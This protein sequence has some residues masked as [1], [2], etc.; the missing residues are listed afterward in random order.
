[1][2]YNSFIIKDYNFVIL[3]DYIFVIIKDNVFVILKDY[4]LFD[5]ANSFNF[6]DWLGFIYM[7]IRNLYIVI[8][9]IN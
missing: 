5:Q 8:I 9:V 3:K 7:V 6:N 1:M 2:D 4:I